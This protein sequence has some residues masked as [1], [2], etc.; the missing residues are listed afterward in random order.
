MTQAEV[1]TQTLPASGPAP[2]RSDWRLVAPWYRWDLAAA[3]DPARAAEAGRPAL[4]KFVTSDFV[5]DFLDDPQCSVVFDPGVDVLQRVS[6]IPA[7]T[8]PGTTTRKWIS[9][10]RLQPHPSGLRK[11]FL[12][13]HQR[14]YLVAVEL[15]CDRP[16]YPS[17]A[18]E[19]V[20]E[21]G[22]VVRRRRTEVPHDLA[23]E[24]AHLV[25]QA[26][27]RE[28][29]AGLAA[30]RERSRILHPFRSEAQSRVPSVPAALRA[31]AQQAELDHRRLRTWAAANGIEQTTEGWTPLGEGSLGAWVP[32]PDEPEEVVERTYP[33]RRLAADPDDPGHA[34]H[35]GTIYY[36]VLPVGSDE[37]TERGAARFNEADTFE[38]R[39]F[40]RTMEG[41]CPGRL[42]WSEPSQP[43]R[44]ASFYDPDGC[45]QRPLEVRL[46]D[47]RQ[48]EASDAAPSVR[49][50]A[51]PGSTLRFPKDG[52]IPSNG[53]TTGPEQ[54]CF[55]SIPLITIVAFFV[56][57][58][59]LPVVMFVFGLWWMLKLKLCLPPSIAVEGEIS[60][61]LD[62][63]PPGI[64]A[65]AGIDVDV[66]PG[67][68]PAA[69]AGALKHV[70][71]VPDPVLGLPPPEWR[72]GQHLLDGAEPLFSPNALLQVAIRNGYGRA[73]EV[74]AGPVFAGG[75]QHRPRV[76]RHEVVRP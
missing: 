65:M 48:L 32:L 73:T 58:I 60:A 3:P 24:A 45:A 56:L 30:A 36:A 41:D 29:K 31:A 27:L 50:S 20:A 39:A 47:F 44:I 54:I 15:H 61:A 2:A 18:P 33:M 67:T 66:L 26:K 59:F 68:D 40:A 35:R 11:V 75:V 21:V 69:L 53:R 55:F 42:V 4:H 74:E 49:M 76:E 43:Y 17:V 70:F 10:T 9:S 7:G 25:R 5:K 23:V 64:Q 63:E 38:V 12:P 62:V 71:D 57:N 37:V 28:S 6:S 8:V 1:Q 13:A 14:F 72:V 51:P 22:L 52:E 34:A 16:G 46:P 19:H